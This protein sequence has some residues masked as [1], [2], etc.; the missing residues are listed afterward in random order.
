MHSLPPLTRYMT[1]LQLFRTL[2]DY[3][4]LSLLVRRT[5]FEA[6]LRKSG[7][8]S[9]FFTDLKS[10]KK[11]LHSDNYQVILKVAGLRDKIAKLKVNIKERE[12]ILAKKR[13]EAREV[14]AELAA[15]KAEIDEAMGERDKTM[16]ALMEHIEK[17]NGS[18][19][20]QVVN[21]YSRMGDKE[22][23][24]LEMISIVIERNGDIEGFNR[25]DHGHYFSQR[26]E[27]IAILNERRM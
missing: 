26:E 12:A 11:N 1:F 27:L 6:F 20:M 23:K 14:E 7:E 21:F 16:G 10:T 19:Y 13:E 18:E 2:Y 5:Y 4:G 8:F 22:N 24:L 17:V 3:L 15:N 25:A 9:S